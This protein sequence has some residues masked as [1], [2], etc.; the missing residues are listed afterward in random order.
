MFY[1]QQPTTN[2]P[3]LLLIIDSLFTGGA[4]YS[5]LLW[6]EWL[7][8]R[9]Y[10]VRL[11]LLK[12]K[13]PSYK[14]EDFKISKDKVQQLLPGGIYSKYKQLKKIINEFKP[15]IVHSVLNASN[16]LTRAIKLTGGKFKHVESVVN[17]PY[18]PER[19]QDN[20]IVSWKIKML[21]V[22]DHITQG[23]GVNHFHANSQ[24]VADHY[25]QYVGVPA[26]KITVIPRG[27]TENQYIQQRAA[28]RTH[29][30]QELRLNPDAI[31][32]IN[33]GRHE[34]QKAHDVLIQAIFQLKTDIS[35]EVLIAGREGA[36]TEMLKSLVAKH[37]LENK[38]HFLGH[39]TDISQ[40]L[41]ASDIFVFP[42]RYEGMPGALIEA[43]TAG[44]P[45][46]CTDLPCMHEVVDDRSALFFSINDSEALAN[47]INTL[48]SNSNLRKQMG[49]V[50]LKLFEEKFQ[51]EGIHQ[52][53]LLVIGC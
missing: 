20:R 13:T 36:N 7:E 23:T 3:Q 53:M 16:F 38:I 27:R 40:L 11:V 45:A 32:L 29:Y 44:L 43:C 4:E 17:Q 6:M 18:A 26:N 37:Q 25:I 28:L 39:R 42:S 19:L 1:N 50:A 47:Q 46:I 31:W 15:D 41:V 30:A 24:A 52:R 2:N 35:F 22:Y 21:N 10:N 51:L 48:L 9:G 5:T 12:P 14:I 8:E 34:Y 49:N 33:T